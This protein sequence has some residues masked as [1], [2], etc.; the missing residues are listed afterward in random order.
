MRVAL[1]HSFYDDASPSGENM[2]VENQ[3]RALHKAG[4]EVELFG[5]RTTDRRSEPL[6]RVRSAFRVATGLGRHPARIEDF[7]PDVVH[8]HN[9]FPNFGRRWVKD[10]A[11]PVVATLHNYRPLCANG[12]LLRDDRVCTRCPDG[13]P[14]SSLRYACYRGSRV[15]TAPLTAATWGASTRDPILTTLDRLLV[16]STSMAR[17]YE[18]AGVDSRRLTVLPNFL[19]DEARPD[20]RKA[21][22][23]TDSW[24]FVGR[25][26][27][28]KGILDLVRRWPQDR[29]LTVAGDGPQ[30]RELEAAGQGKRIEF[31]GSLDRASILGLMQ[32]SI[33]LVFPSRWLEGAPLVYVEALASGLPVL[34][35]RPNVLAELAEEQG[36]GQ[37]LTWES[38]LEEALNE[39]ASSF[40]TLR[41]RCAAVFEAEYSESA[42]VDRLESVYAE[43]A[44]A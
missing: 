4:H 12:F 36:T 2:V 6:Y 27:S 28:E 42:F 25:L 13:A 5:A 16:L 11:T 3:L 23:R 37:T 10:L 29:A 9:L 21:V 30:R 7:A 38:E 32:R 43:V 35:W 15:A 1:V 33:G 31:L 34:A 40:P 26:S 8:V 18:R 41:G 20:L 22:S 39:A 44:R 19:P 17:I 24:L 14:L